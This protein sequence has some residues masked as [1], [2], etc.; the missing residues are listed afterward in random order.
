MQA[1]EEIQSVAVIGAGAIG[2][3]YG[4]RLAHAGID[5][6]F[7][8]RSDY[9][10]VSKHGLSVSS[11]D[12]D[13]ELPEVSCQ[14]AS[15]DIG[16]VDLV[17]VAWK[18]TSNKNYHRVI[19]PLLHENTLIITLQNGLGST[20]ELAHLFGAHRVYGALCFIG[21]NRLSPGRIDHAATAG[22]TKV[23][24][25]EPCGQ[26]LGTEGRERLDRLVDFLD[27]GGVSCEAEESLERAQ[28]MKLIWNIPFN[29]LT[30]S[31]GGV[32]TSVLFT[33]VDMESSMTKSLSFRS[34]R[35]SR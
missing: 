8:L 20:D 11:I 14:R 26:A 24:K 31:E 28:W 32:D 16:H 6:T 18:T 13:F 5:I 9:E 19:T 15:E 3:Y 7:L 21:V 12:G 22:P 23:G 33:I 4:A 1:W 30:I 29:G 10:H 35:P 34:K 27:R 25:Y 2:S 17:I